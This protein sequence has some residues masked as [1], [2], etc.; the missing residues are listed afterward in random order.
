CMFVLRPVLLYGAE[1]WALR[2]K[3]EGMLQRTE[4]RMVRWIAGISLSEKRRSE[5]IRKICGICNIKEKA[6]E[7]RLRY[8]GHVKRRGDEEPMKK[9]MTTEV[10]GK[11][12]VGRP[13]LRW[14]DVTRN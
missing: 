7:A 4:M 5:D 10:E 9:A 3:E 2:K 14:R 11:R 6:R 1:T 8:F 12:N 13:R